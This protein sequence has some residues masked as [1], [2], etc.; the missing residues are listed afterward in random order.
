MLNEDPYCVKKIILKY[1]KIKIII[2]GKLYKNRENEIQNRCIRK[3]Q[4][5]SI[6]MSVIKCKM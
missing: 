1:V 2:V 5:N 3:T 4:H 6:K